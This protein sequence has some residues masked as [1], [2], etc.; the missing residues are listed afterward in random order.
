MHAREVRRLGEPAVGAGDRPLSPDYSSQTDDA[1]ADEL[2]V[3][4]HVGGVADKPRHCT[5]PTSPSTP[6][7][8]H[9]RTPR[10]SPGPART[11]VAPR[12]GPGWRRRHTESV[13]AVPDRHSLSSG[14]P[15][16]YSDSNLRN[17]P[18]S[19]AVATSFRSVPLNGTQS[20]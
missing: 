1:L 13:H 10:R 16:P 11:S 18:G 17:R 20:S 12:A 3:L 7:T 9:G 2:R 5:R 4:T 6:G 15:R 8:H 19:V 14:R